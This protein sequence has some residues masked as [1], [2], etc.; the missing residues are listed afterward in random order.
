VVQIGDT[1]AW[2][3]AQGDPA[4]ETVSEALDQAGAKVV[5]IGRRV[6]CLATDLAR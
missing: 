5:G 6:A 2:A 4:D 1:I 3:A